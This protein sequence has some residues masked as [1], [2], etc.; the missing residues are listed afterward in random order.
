M[1]SSSASS[2]PR[3]TKF[4]PFAKSG[5]LL[6]LLCALAALSS[7]VGYRLGGWDYQFG[8]A[9]LKWA[10][11]GG[12][13]AALVSLI[14]AVITRPGS[15][16]RGFV[17]GVSGLVIGLAVFAGPM[18]ML[19]TAKRV[20]P[21]HDISTDTVDPPPFVAILPLRAGAANPAEYGA[22]AVAKQQLAAAQQAAYP[23][24]RPLR[25][26][27]PVAQVTEMA[28]KT[29]RALGWEIVASVPAEGRMEAT[30]TTLL[31][32]FKD[33]IVVRVS[34]AAQG[35]RVDVRSV[36]RVGKS[37]LGINAKRI[38]KFLAALAAAAK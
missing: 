28:A 29:A 27:A 38:E 26:D 35:S 34:T 13:A 32:G 24:I 36:S 12:V 20:P 2:I 33:D 30:D 9:I 5:F 16:R 37:D 4:S 10:A 14:G 21:I 17:L 31:Y 6:A 8:F 23:R 25:L 19:R 3:S 22:D 11:Y 7:G 1:T 15:K 18:S